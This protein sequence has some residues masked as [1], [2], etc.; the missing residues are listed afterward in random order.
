MNDSKKTLIKGIILLM[1][2]AIIGTTYAYFA[3]SITGAESTST[4]VA[5]GG[6]M[7]IVYDN[8]SGAINAPNIYPREE[9]W[10][11]KNFTVTGNNSTTKDMKYKLVLK[12]DKNTFSKGTITVTPEAEL[13]TIPSA[14]TYSL[15]SINTSNK[16]TVVPSLTNQSIN[17]SEISLGIGSFPNGEDMVHTYTFELFFKDTGENQNADQG[18][19]FAA[20]I[21][22]KEAPFNEIALSASN[23]SS[24]GYTDG[25]VPESL[26]IPEKYQT[27][28]G[29]YN[30]VTSIVTDAFPTSTRTPL[31]SLTLN[32]G[33]ESIGVRAFYTSSNLTGSIIMPSTVKTIGALAFWGTD[34]TGLTLNEGLESIG[35]SAFGGVTNLTGTLT[36]P[37]TVK[38]IG[39]YAFGQTGITGL[40]LNEGLESIGE[41]AFWNVTNLTGTLTIPSTV[42][43]IGKWAFRGTNIT[44]LT[45]NEGLESIGEETF[46]SITNLTGNLTIPSTLKSIGN[47]V[48]ENTGITG[49]TL[50]EGLESIGES[51]FESSNNL[52]GSITMPS[53]VKSIGEFAFYETGI[54]GLTLNEGLESI[55][56]VAF[57]RAS[58]LTGTLT[59]PS[60][61]KTIGIDAFRYTGITGLTLNEGLESIGEYAFS[62]TTNLTST[63]T[64]PSTVKTIGNA[65]FGGTGITGLTLNEG[66]ET[67]G[68]YAFDY[69]SNL[70][71]TITIPSTVKSIGNYAFRGTS[72]TTIN[73]P[74]TRGEWL[75]IAR[76]SGILPSGVTINYNYTGA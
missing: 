39:N 22:I 40:T 24:I 73:Y 1:L 55:G 21:S 33:L 46:S 74:G 70:T 19:Q 31:T 29:E 15:T 38:T 48:F 65:A 56:D 50:N 36:I 76:Y 52:T 42:K 47:G 5:S 51:A 4:L 45:L 9:A 58:N 3:A 30:Q 11:T 37:S 59:I 41:Q 72:I 44:G 61:V 8:L 26:V 18:K 17:I 49:L 57:S 71:G 43:T 13:V 12:V 32:E 23:L 54:T 16:G 64:I 27:S 67:I 10:I 60:T 53:T 35:E 68:E 75:K 69:A 14:L 2:V 6:T 20:Y 25:V 66:L 62:G 34:I 63:V 28:S 7:E